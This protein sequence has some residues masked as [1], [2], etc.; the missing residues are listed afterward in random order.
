MPDLSIIVVNYRSW[1]KLEGCL[2]SLDQQGVRAKKVIV[3][4]NH[5]NDGILEVFIKKFPFQLLF[6]LIEHLFLF[7]GVYDIFESKKQL[8]LLK[9]F[10]FFFN[11]YSKSDHNNP[12]HNQVYFLPYR[13]ILKELKLYQVLLIWFLKAQVSQIY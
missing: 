7:L 13:M 10:F 8:R 6:Y 1:S 2:Q 3:I 5:S 12:F 4:D 9:Y 11:I